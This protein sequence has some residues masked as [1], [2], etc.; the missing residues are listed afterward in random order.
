MKGL[1]LAAGLGTRLLPLTLCRAKPAMP[2]RDRPLICYC[3]QSLAAAGLDEVAVNL[4]HLPDSVRQAVGSA[5]V[6]PL[7]IRYS[8]EPEILGTAGALN[9]M[10]DWLGQDLFLLVNGKVVFDFDLRPAIEHHR[11][12]GAL[13]TLILVDR[14]A[15]EKFN[16]VFIDDSGF[17]TGFAETP[18]EREKPG[19]TFTGI[20]LLDSRIWRFVPASGFSDMVKAVYREALNCRQKIACYHATGSW[21]EFSTLERYWRLN[22]EATGTSIG[23]GSKI[24]GS[25]ELINSVIWDNVDLGDEC[26]LENCVVADDV[27]VPPHSRLKHSV[28]VPA[29]LATPQ[30]QQYVKS[31]LIIYPLGTSS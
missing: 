16:P 28:L 2:Y 19:L 20:H 14:V 17:V 29:R 12:S 30:F 3:L 7:K 9:P 27:Q 23:A 15:G 26:L 8:F 6:G 1:V 24:S 11:C 4:H 31:G 18:Q 13:A 5:Q 21:L 22:I 25:A 10:R